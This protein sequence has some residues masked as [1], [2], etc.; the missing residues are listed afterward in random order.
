MALG[1]RAIR[2]AVRAVTIT[3]ARMIT[4]AVRAFRTRVSARMRIGITV[5]T[6]IAVLAVV[7]VLVAEE[8]PENEQNDDDYYYE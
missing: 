6:V 1:V 8:S 5:M 2:V 7:V 4:R 3:I